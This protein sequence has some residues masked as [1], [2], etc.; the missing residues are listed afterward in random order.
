MTWFYSQSQGTL[1]HDTE[2]V[3]KGYSGKGIDCNNHGSESKIGYGPIPRGLYTIGSGYKHSKLGSVTMNLTP[4][5][6]NAHGR[7]AFR[8]H[9][10]SSAHPGA[11]SEGCI[12]LPLAVRQRIDESNDKELCVG[13]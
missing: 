12:V 6:H 1:W 7:T 9:G 13:Y 4:V 5:G 8:I 3:G 11:A 10:D 2:E